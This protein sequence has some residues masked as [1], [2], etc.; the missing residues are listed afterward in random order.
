MPECPPSAF[1]KRAVG[2]HPNQR[3]G[4][5]EH[6]M[7]TFEHHV[8]SLY[9]SLGG[10][11]GAEA[12]DPGDSYYVDILERSLSRDPIRALA[13]SISLASS[14]SVNLLTGF[15]GNGK[16]TQLRRLKQLLEEQG[17]TVFLVDMQRYVL[18]TKP[19]ELSDFLLSLMAALAESVKRMGLGEPLTQSYTERLR[20]FFQSEVQIE[21]L[22]LD[23]GIGKIGT[24][25]QTDAGFKAKLQ[26]ALRDRV[27]RLVE[28]ARAFVV[29][30]VG[31]VRK[32][33][34]EPNRRVVLLVDSMEQLRGP[35]LAG[36]GDSAQSDSWQVYSSAVTLFS[37]EASNLRFPQLH[38][39]YTVPPYLVSLAPNVARSFG[40]ST[41]VMWPNLHVRTRAGTPD[42]DGLGLMQ[43]IVNRRYADWRSI[44][45][46]EA[47][48]R[49]ALS[50]GGDLRDFFRLLRDA[51]LSL[52]DAQRKHGTTEL[53]ATMLTDAEQRLRNEFGFLSESDRRW[54]TKIHDTHDPS[55]D[56]N[57]RFVDLARFFDSN[58]IMNYING[59]PWYDVH[60]LLAAELQ[61]QASRG[62]SRR[63]ERKRKR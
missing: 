55:L 16:S 7:T 62:A 54:L 21:S 60:P 18:L 53:D 26:N 34:K 11:R 9:Q 47:L 36:P 58:M 25:L 41:L 17:C 12:L 35:S 45:S 24:K 38:I 14:E 63:R 40:A 29:E 39:V 61:S 22:E 2:L 46:V 23:G 30:I 13:D 1:G 20:A 5:I 50:S 43:E 49:A 33:S 32:S 27:T 19:I 37:G 57:D 42:P 15:R 8:R 51:L 48:Q 10:E 59:E 31:Y 44:A 28:D 3:A 4:I 56:S 52:L 6:A